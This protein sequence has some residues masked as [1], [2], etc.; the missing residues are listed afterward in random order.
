MISFHRQENASW[1]MTGSC[2]PSSPGELWPLL[3]AKTTSAI[4]SRQ[5][6]HGHFLPILGRRM[7]LP[8]KHN[9]SDAAAG[10]QDTRDSNSSVQLHTV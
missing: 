9:L 1:A 2:L 4:Q 7:C 8:H 10:T 5:L 3:P 6:F